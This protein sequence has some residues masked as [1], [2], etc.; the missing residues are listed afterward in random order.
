MDLS[1][2]E[3]SWTRRVERS[4]SRWSTSGTLDL[5]TAGA[6]DACESSCCAERGWSKGTTRSSDLPV[7]R[8]AVCWGDE[9]KNVETNVLNMDESSDVEAME[10]TRAVWAAAAPWTSS[11]TSPSVRSGDEG[12]ASWAGEPCLR[13][14]L[15]PRLL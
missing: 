9:P 3:S 8:S 6:A 7:I 14:L 13:E 12:T 11:S 1:L 4:A 10:A 15:P 2:C 5:R